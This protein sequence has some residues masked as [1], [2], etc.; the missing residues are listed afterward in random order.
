MQKRRIIISL[1]SC[2]LIT[3]LVS[4]T[5]TLLLS[6]PTEQY[7]PAISD[8]F[9]INPE[10][11]ST[12]ELPLKKIK[13]TVSVVCGGH[14]E[15]RKGLSPL[16]L[17]IKYLEKKLDVTFT[18]EKVILK[19]EQP[20]G[21]IEERWEKWLEIAHA[22][23]ASKSDLTIILLESYPDNVDTFDFRSEGV[24]GLASGIGVLGSPA[25]A[26]LLAK[27]MGSEKF[28]TRLLIHEIG[29]T[30]GATHIEEGIMHPCACIN[31]YADELSINSLDQI[32]AHLGMVRL[33]RTLKSIPKQTKEPHT[34]KEQ[35]HSPIMEKMDY[36]CH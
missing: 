21:T 15:C 18:I 8:S 31:Q 16:K 34:P 19:S 3:F 13:F 33:Y 23:G 6:G 29:H 20:D 26:A 7:T 32:K 24:I 22:A 35:N 36:D 1:L 14:V 11:A 17:A 12:G 4:A 5:F 10:Y 25:P 27:V 2:L 9:S 28:M 30:L